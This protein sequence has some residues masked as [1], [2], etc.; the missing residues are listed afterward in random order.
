MALNNIQCISIQ[1]IYIMKKYLLFIL[2]STMSLMAFA[3]RT[4]STSIPVPL[5][6]TDP[7]P[8]DKPKKKSP[9]RP[10][11]LSVLYTGDVL[12][13]ESPIDLG[14]VSYAIKDEDD[15]I[16]LSGNISIQQG[17]PASLSIAALPLGC[18]ILEVQVGER[19]YA[20]E[21]FINSN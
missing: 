12:Y 21:F 13:F 3:E 15:T 20:G 6:P 16:V 7:P 4:D 8:N 17:L 11:Q 9:I 14:I 2:L 5:V 1:R 19:T 18:Y 10:L